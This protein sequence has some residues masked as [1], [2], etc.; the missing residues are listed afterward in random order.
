MTMALLCNLS[1]LVAQ[2]QYNTIQFGTVRCGAV[3]CTSSDT[4]PTTE[5]LLCSDSAAGNVNVVQPIVNHTQSTDGNPR[6]RLHIRDTR[7]NSPD[8]VRN[9]DKEMG[10]WLGTA[11]GPVVDDN[12]ETSDQPTETA[13]HR[14]SITDQR[15]LPRII[16]TDQSKSNI[17][18]DE[19]GGQLSDDDDDTVVHDDRGSETGSD[20]AYRQI[21]AVEQDGDTSKSSAD[22]EVQRLLQELVR[23]RKASDRSQGWSDFLEKELLAHIDARIAA[24]DSHKRTLRRLSNTRLANKRVKQRCERLQEELRELHVGIEQCVGE[25]NNLEFGK[26][27]IGIQRP[28]YK[29]SART[30][31]EPDI[32]LNEDEEVDNVIRLLDEPRPTVEEVYIE[33]L[34]AK[35]VFSADK[36]VYITSPS[37]SSTLSPTVMCGGS[38]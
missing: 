12:A 8:P 15:Q 36:G 33:E 27:A 31:E 16:I 23:A 6:L 1:V 7:V 21:V 32:Q 2:I 10:S 5:R 24:E 22:F 20:A 37:S 11:N 13:D 3:Q 29:K 34:F 18:C 26:K 25:N 35:E 14:S 19:W 9:F 28:H 30:I 17:S 4:M 38:F